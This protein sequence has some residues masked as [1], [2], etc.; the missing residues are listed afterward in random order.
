MKSPA[1]STTEPTIL[2]QF[3]AKILCTI[4]GN[5][6]WVDTGKGDGWI[7][8]EI[9]ADILLPLDLPDEPGLPANYSR[10]EYADWREW[11]TKS[12]S[13]ALKKRHLAI[14]AKCIKAHEKHLPLRP[15]IRPLLELADLKP[16]G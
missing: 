2:N 3:C 6:G 11:A 16:G 15:E 1:A 4:L 13:V 10:A 14:A 9:Q 7:A 5:P 8:G 12:V